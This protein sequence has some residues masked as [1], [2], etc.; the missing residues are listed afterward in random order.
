[1]DNRSIRERFPLSWTV[2]ETPGGY[3]VDAP[4]GTRLCYVYTFPERLMPG[5]ADS[6]L[7]PAEGLAIAK[8]FA[9]MAAGDS[10]TIDRQRIAAVTQ[11]Q[12][13]GW[14]WREGAWEPPANAGAAGQGVAAAVDVLLAVLACRADALAGCMP[15]SAEEVELEAIGGAIEAYESA[16]WPE[17]KIPSGKG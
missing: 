17:G 6:K 13:Q 9:A 8:A 5:H 2:A 16:R 3:R 10:M 7:K 15:G 12:A 4:C 1:M 14:T 11:L